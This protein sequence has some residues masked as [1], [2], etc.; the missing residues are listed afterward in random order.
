M[1]AYKLVSCKFKWFGIQNRVEKFIQTVSMRKYQKALLS[2]SLH[3]TDFLAMYGVVSTIHAKY[4]IFN[5][6]TPFH[7]VMSYTNQS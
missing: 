2:F 7:I 4:S 1:C 5:L 6:M 3:F